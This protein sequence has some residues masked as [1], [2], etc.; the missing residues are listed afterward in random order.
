M[1]KSGVKYYARI[2]VARGG[3]DGLL[4]LPL[5][6]RLQVNIGDG[7]YRAPDPSVETN[8]TSPSA[9]CVSTARALPC[10]CVCP[11]SIDAEDYILA[12]KIVDLDKNL[13]YFPENTI[14]YV[15]DYV[16]IGVDVCSLTVK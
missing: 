15:C 3:N 12:E 8:S 1:T 6:K 10:M 14:R 9:S 13:G 2:F 4:R 5:N 11:L 7:Y 16:V